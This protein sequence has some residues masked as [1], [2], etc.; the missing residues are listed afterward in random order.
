MRLIWTGGVPESLQW[1]VFQGFLEAQPILVLPKPAETLGFNCAEFSAPQR[2]SIN[3]PK[4][5]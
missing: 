4:Y 3:D 1:P 2:F 5:G